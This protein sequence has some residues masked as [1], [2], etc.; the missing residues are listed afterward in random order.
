MIRSGQPASALLHS[1]DPVPQLLKNVRF[2]EGQAPLDAASV[3]T[4]IADAEDQLRGN[5]RLLIRTSGT[6]PLIRVMAES[7]DAQVLE[8]AVDSV[9]DAI[10]AVVVT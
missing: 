7:E 3:K 4:A 2:A 9:V 8:S 5:G 10:E 1:F 6:E